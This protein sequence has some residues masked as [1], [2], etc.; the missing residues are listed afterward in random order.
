M[1]CPSNQRQHLEIHLSTYKSDPVL[2][3]LGSRV[4]YG[5][6]TAAFQ[7]IDTIV[8]GPLENKVKQDFFSMLGDAT[9]QPL[10]YNFFRVYEGL[11]REALEGHLEKP[12]ILPRSL[13]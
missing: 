10:A 11:N 1:R 5:D 4:Q 13:V 2:G 8:V 6:E 9:G 7:Y 12:L 3:P